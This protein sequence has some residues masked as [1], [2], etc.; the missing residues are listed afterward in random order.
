[1]TTYHYHNIPSCIRNA[2]EGSSTVVGWILDGFPVV[3]ERDAKGSL[4]SNADLDECHGRTSDIVV[5][6]KTVNMYHYSA[7]LEFPYFIGCYRG[8]RSVRDKCCGPV[9][10]HSVGGRVVDRALIAEAGSGIDDHWHV[11]QLAQR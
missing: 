11:I 2:S 7:T 5:D 8:T 3:V 1:M 4:P 9:T 10:D 6:G